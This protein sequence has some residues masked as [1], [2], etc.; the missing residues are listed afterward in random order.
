M[1]SGT[2]YTDLQSTS[3]TRQCFG[4]GFASFFMEEVSFSLFSV[5]V[6]G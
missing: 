2:S 4:E 1:G 3:P 6:R 5:L